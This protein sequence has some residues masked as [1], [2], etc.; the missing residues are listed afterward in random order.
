M[1]K[2]AMITDTYP[3]RGYVIETSVDGKTYTELTSGTTL[4]EEIKFIS[5]GETLARYIRFTVTKKVATS[6][7]GLSEFQVFLT[8]GEDAKVEADLV[9]LKYQLGSLMG[10]T[11]NLDLPT[12]GALYG[13]KFVYTSS[14]TSALTNDGTVISQSTTKSGTLRVDAYAKTGEENGTPVYSATKSAEESYSFSVSGKGGGTGGT[15]VGPSGGGSGGS[16]GGGGIGAALPTSPAVNSVVGNETGTQTTGSFNDVTRDYWGYNYI[17]TLKSRQ[18]VSGDGSGNFNPDAQ[19]TREEFLKMLMNALGIAID[20]IK[21]VNL[22]DVSQDDW[23][24]PYIA[25]G[26]E[27]GVTTGISETEFGTG[28]YITRED[29]AVMSTRAL[30]VVKRTLSQTE[31]EKTFTDEGQISG[32]AVDSVKVMQQ[33]GVIGGYADGT[34][35]PQQNATRAEAAKIICG[36]LN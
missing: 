31:N 1:L 24:Y 25:K 22:S 18:I 6:N 32:Y 10:L 35:G 16:S 9:V 28:N 36:I 5:V 12:T 7:V 15:A 17:E 29:M 34:F 30:A 14:D 33:C 27:M 19:I 4:G 26:L 8:G 13:T 11:S 23:Y 2:E 3:L 21:D 20:N